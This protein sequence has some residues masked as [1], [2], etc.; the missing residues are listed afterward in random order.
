MESLKRLQFTKKAPSTKWMKKLVQ[1]YCSLHFLVHE[2]KVE[3]ACRKKVACIFWQTIVR[4]SHGSIPMVSCMLLF[5]RPQAVQTSRF[6]VAR[7]PM[8]TCEMSYIKR[9]W[10]CSL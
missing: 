4:D 1:L 10:K 9:F 5:H 7:V 2:S 6:S 8:D 3:G